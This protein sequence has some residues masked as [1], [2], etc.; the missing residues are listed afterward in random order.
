MQT[1][2]KESLSKRGRVPVPIKH[3]GSAALLNEKDTFVCF[4]NVY[5]CL[6][7][8]LMHPD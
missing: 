4:I 5:L 1:D 6:D 8:L 7:A 2:R 3:G